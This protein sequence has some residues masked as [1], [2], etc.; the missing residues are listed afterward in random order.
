MDKYSN[1]IEKEETDPFSKSN[2]FSKFFFNW[3]SSHV[4]KGY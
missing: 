3:A 1:L 4:A 2:I